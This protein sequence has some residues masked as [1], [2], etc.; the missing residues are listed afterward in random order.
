MNAVARVTGV[1]GATLAL[2][3]AAFFYLPQFIL[4]GLTSVDRGARVWLATIWVAF[5]FGVACY[6]AW[7]STAPVG[8]RRGGAPADRHGDTPGAP[9]S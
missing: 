2:L 5:A 1:V 4:T 6:A 3:V 7:R 8:N 9:V